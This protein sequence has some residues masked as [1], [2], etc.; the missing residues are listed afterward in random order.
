[1]AQIKKEFEANLTHTRELEEANRKHTRELAEM[2]E[3][4]KMAKE[5]YERAMRRGRLK[6]QI[7]RRHSDVVFG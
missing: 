1:L 2:R 3:G 7:M 4:W 6:I 5:T